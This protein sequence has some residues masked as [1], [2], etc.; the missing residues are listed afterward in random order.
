MDGSYGVE[1]LGSVTVDETSILVA[2][3][4]GDTVVFP[5]RDIV[6]VWI[7]GTTVLIAIQVPSS[8]IAQVSV[9]HS[10]TEDAMTLYREL[11]IRPL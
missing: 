2:T 4:G 8:Q 5:R 1:G 7:D 3:S 9:T 10:S 6:H 11:S